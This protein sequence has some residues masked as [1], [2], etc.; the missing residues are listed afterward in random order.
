MQPEYKDAVNRDRYK[1]FR[2]PQGP[3]LKD[4]GSIFLRRSFQFFDQTNPHDD[5]L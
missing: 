5:A 1:S 4:K 3:Y 2:W